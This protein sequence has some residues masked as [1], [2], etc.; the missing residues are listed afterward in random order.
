MSAPARALRLL[1]EVAYRDEADA[2]LT[3]PGDAAL[4]VRGRQRSLI[5][6]CPDGCGEML[7][8]NLDARAGKA[9]RIDQRGEGVTLVPSVWRDGGCDSHFIVWRGFILWCDRFVGENVEPPYDSRLEDFVLQ[10][11]RRDE[12]RAA[13][14]IAEVIDELVWDVD[15]A[16][17]RL[18][19]R[20]LA[21]VS[22]EDGAW[23]FYRAA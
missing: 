20:G 3:S 12:P 6:A 10:A 23:L 16:A 18:V 19:G 22:R 8:V 5:V 14:T 2:L 21:G 4:V 13:I 15:R 9:W 17:R 1:G 11:L 7:V